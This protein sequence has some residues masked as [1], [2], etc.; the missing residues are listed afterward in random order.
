MGG[1]GVEDALNFDVLDYKLKK[2]AA[3]F[4]EG[5]HNGLGIY[6]LGA[7]VGLL[8]EVG[9]E[10]IA[11]RLQLL[12]EQLIEGLVVLGFQIL[13]PIE[14]DIRSGIVLAALAEDPQG[15]RLNTLERHLFSK[16]IYCTLRSGGIRFSPHFYNT[17]EEIEKT[18]KEIKSFLESE[19]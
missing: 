14:P 1:I 19:G 18:L 11:Q 8:L 16:G 4:E 7:A 12:T 2:T 3:R 13:S 9:V 6:G 15:A 17:E 10:R 5:S